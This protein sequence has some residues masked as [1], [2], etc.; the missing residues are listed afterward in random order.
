MNNECKS[1]HPLYVTHDFYF[2][3]LCVIANIWQHD[4]QRKQRRKHQE[5]ETPRVSIL[6][7]SRNCKFQELEQYLK[8]DVFNYEM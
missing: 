3:F 7:I 8:T 5:T 2:S 1:I 4:M 6:I